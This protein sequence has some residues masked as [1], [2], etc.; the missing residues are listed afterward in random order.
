MKEAKPETPFTFVVPPADFNVK[1]AKDADL[2][3]YGYPP[4]PNG[5]ASPKHQALWERIIERPFR[6]ISPALLTQNKSL[7]PAQMPAVGVE[8]LN[9]SGWAGALNTSLPSG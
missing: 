7:R 6:V 9:T 2:V 8:R 1:K 3:K 5:N 4:R